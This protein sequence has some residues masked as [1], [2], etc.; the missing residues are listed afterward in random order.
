MLLQD[1]VAIVT[2]G[3]SG[4]GEATVKAYLNKGVR[5]AIFDMNPPSE[6]S[7]SEFSDTDYAFY[8]VDVTNEESVQTAINSVVEHF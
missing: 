8:Q 4:L 1:K 2:G 3:A 5:V 7:F 6:A